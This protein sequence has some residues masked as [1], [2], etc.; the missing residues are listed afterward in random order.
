MRIVDGFR[1]GWTAI[2]IGRLL[3]V[4]PTLFTRFGYLLITSIDSSTDVGGLA[5]GYHLLEH[6]TGCSLLG[7]GLVVPAAQLAQ[8]AREFNLF[9]GF[10][11]VWCFD[12]RPGVAMPTMI[13]LVAPLNVERDPP[14]HG[15]EE[16]MRQSGCTLGLGDGDGLNYVTVMLEL[17][18]RIERAVTA[19]G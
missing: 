2:S 4:D 1:F 11:E 6:C 12:R 17:A 10:D 13:A 19:G 8:I 9:N 3:A 15:L 18:E 14:P 5:T 16:W 7:E